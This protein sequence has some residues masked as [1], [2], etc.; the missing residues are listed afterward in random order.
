MNAQKMPHGVGSLWVRLCIAALQL[1]KR[2]PPSSP[3]LSKDAVLPPSLHGNQFSG[4]INIICIV[5]TVC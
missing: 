2:L 1:V 4:R 5:R 3:A